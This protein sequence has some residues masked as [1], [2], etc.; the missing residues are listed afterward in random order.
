VE[1]AEADPFGDTGGT[2]DVAYVPDRQHNLPKVGQRVRVYVK[3]DAAGDAWLLEPNG[4]EP[5]EA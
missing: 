4:W 2:I 5:A 1:E 3:H